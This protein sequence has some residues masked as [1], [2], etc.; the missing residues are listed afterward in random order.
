M[1]GD[2]KPDL[3]IVDSGLEIRFQDPANPGVFQSPVVLAS[4]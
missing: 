4:Q 2:Y 1:N 3:V